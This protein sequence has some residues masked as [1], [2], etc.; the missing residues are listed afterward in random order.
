MSEFECVT[1]SLKKEGARKCGWS[2]K[3][4]ILSTPQSVGFWQA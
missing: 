1:M 3:L 4:K 2:S